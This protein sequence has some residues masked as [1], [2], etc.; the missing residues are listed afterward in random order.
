MGEITAIEWCDHTFNPSGSSLRRGPERE[1]VGVD[2]FMTAVAKRDSI[3]H[4]KPQVGVIGEAADVV[5]VKVAATV[6]A[7]VSAGEPVTKV[8]VVAPALQFWG[9]AQP[10]SLSALAV[11]VARR[12]FAPS[13]LQAGSGTDLCP[14]FDGVSFA[15]HRAGAAFRRLAHLRPALVGHA[16]ALHRRNEGRA[17]LNPR[18][19]NDFA[20]AHWSFGHG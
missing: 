1:A 17:A 13:S 20:A 3:P 7:T 18:F 6:I 5:G 19:P 10:A 9:G 11:D 4:V 15:L 2:G 14:R 16:L 12:V 8:N